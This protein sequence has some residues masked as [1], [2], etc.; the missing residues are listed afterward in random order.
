M[1]DRLPLAV[2]TPRQ[3]KISTGGSI[4]IIADWSA[5]HSRSVIDVYTITGYTSNTH[6]DIKTATGNN[7]TISTFDGSIC[8]LRH[9]GGKRI[10]A[11]YGRDVFHWC[12]V[13][14]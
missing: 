9:R 1:S 14:R 8:R 11:F 13:G 10:R 6:D 3:S 2:A 5:A 7:P 4:T 12:D